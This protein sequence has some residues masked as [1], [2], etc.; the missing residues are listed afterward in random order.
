MATSGYTG[1]GSSGLSSF[2]ASGAGNVTAV[3]S[4]TGTGDRIIAKTQY[5]KLYAFTIK[6]TLRDYEDDKGKAVTYTPFA[7]AA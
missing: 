7:R 2:G 6:K 3:A 4:Q 1:T 5:G